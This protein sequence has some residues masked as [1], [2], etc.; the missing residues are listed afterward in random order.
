[1][2]RA[3]PW[4][5]FLTT[6]MLTA[7]TTL[8]VWITIESRD[9][10]RFASALEQTKD[11]IRGRLDQYVGALRGGTGL[12]AASDYVSLAEFRAYVGHVDV[13]HHFP[14]IQGIGFAQRVAPAALDSVRALIRS[15][16]V[17]EYQIQP[18]NAPGDRFP[19]VYL[20]PLDNRNRAAMGFDMYAN[21]VRREAMERAWLGGEP[22]LSG[23]VTLVQELDSATPQPGFL[24]YHPVYAGGRVPLTPAERREK[25]IGFVYGPFRALDLF[26][27]II[28]G[29]QLALRIHDGST[30]D[31]AERLY[32]SMA[33]SLRSPSPLY[34]HVETL[35]FAGHPWTVEF[36]TTR[37]FEGASGRLAIPIIG[38]VGLIVSIVIYRATQAQVEA[39]ARAEE[40]EAARARFFAAMS[41]ELRTPINAI[42]GYN[43]LL[44]GGIYGPL[45]APQA[46]GIERAQKAARHLVELV[47]DVLD[48]SKIEAGKVRLDIEAVDVGEMIDDLSS[49][50]RPMAES[51]GCVLHLDG[52]DCRQVVWTDPRRV[53]QILLNLLSNAAKFGAGKPIG[54]RCLGDGDGGVAIE[55]TD[56]GGGISLEDRERIFE[57]F[58]QLEK[59][60]PEGT[61]LGLAISRRLA[62]LL[63]GTLEVD[64]EPNV[65]STFRLKLPT[66]LPR[67]VQAR[68]R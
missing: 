52:V 41:H 12:F 22:A 45:P 48:L 33:D 10:E 66:R 6:L 35:D 13:Q 11:R 14:G 21:P 28:T 57:E 44:L 49:T 24:I 5:A 32:D 43:D 19:I 39:R 65:G 4:L 27:R 50:I 68:A 1:M 60:D 20:E 8:L 46:H 17:P 59:G 9:Q 63:G 7:A 53:R 47:N 26:N 58:V 37:E 15:Q 16:G 62:A 55:V 67:R 40:S 25:L 54:V 3:A 2:R 38:L 31:P 61:G 29:Q 18:L 36:E 64:S 56:R 42:M 34:R 51:R 23:R 30:P